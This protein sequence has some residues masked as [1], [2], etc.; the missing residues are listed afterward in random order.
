MERSNARQLPRIE[1]PIDPNLSNIF[2]AVTTR[3]WT[4]RGLTAR[5]HPAALTPNLSPILINFHQGIGLDHLDHWL[6]TWKS[7][8]FPSPSSLAD[9]YISF[10]DTNQNLPKDLHA[11]LRRRGFRP[12]LEQTIEIVGNVAKDIDLSRFVLDIRQSFSASIGFEFYRVM[13]QCFP[14]IQRRS[15]EHWLMTLGSSSAE[16]HYV[17][18]RHPSQGAVAVGTINV[19][20]CHKWAFF[21]SGCV[22]PTWRR[23]GLFRRLIQIRQGLAGSEATCGFL[24]SNP[25]LRG[26][27]TLSLPYTTWK[28]SHF[29]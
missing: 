5:F 25:D 20:S 15:V 4:G 11:H 9:P 13:A 17:A 10:L 23:Q 7:L 24:T 16:V 26:K 19:S 6:Y 27:G 8:Y 28:R 22:L 29:R 12:F 14:K 18:I 21:T 3:S 1:S 2:S